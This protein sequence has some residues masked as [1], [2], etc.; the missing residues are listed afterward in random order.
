MTG[1][2]RQRVAEGDPR[3][4]HE[5]LIALNP[6]RLITLIGQQTGI[7]AAEIASNFGYAPSSI[8]W[9]IRLLVAEHIVTTPGF[10]S[11]TSPLTL[12]YTSTQAIEVAE[13]NGIE[14][15]LPLSR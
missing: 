15:D 2:H 8:M 14:L 10:P 13:A 3:I 12:N 11:S 5:R 7:S 4:S 9:V 1:A 6:R